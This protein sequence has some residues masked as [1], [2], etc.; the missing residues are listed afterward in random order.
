MANTLQQQLGNI[1]IYLF[2]QL[3]KGRFDDCKKVLDAGCGGGRNLIY[4]LQNGFE[5]H[6]IDP[7]PDA[8][9]HVKELVKE[10]A[11]KLSAKNFKV[12]P[13]EKLPFKDNEFD[14]VISSAVL[15]FATDSNH[16]D[17]ML[18]SMWRVL[19][20]GGYLFARLASDIGIED[21]VVALGNSCFAL[22]DGSERFLVNEQI[23]LEYT[24][25]LGGELFEPIK[26]TNVQGLRCMTTWCVQKASPRISPKERENSFSF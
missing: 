10:L 6:G 19:K 26:T 5:V 18:R 23:L 11:P 13:A 3:L 2:D 21:K 9:A 22:P 14:L 20:P 1:D 12:T 15:H 16:F 24:S 8:V 7:N 4:F 25:E 17:A